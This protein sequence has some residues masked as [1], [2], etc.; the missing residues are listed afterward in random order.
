MLSP[1]GIDISKASF[2]VELSVNEKLR[3]RRFSNQQ[4]GFKELCAWLAKHKAG[5]VHAC[6][7]ATGR[8]GDDLAVHLYQAGHIVSV[9]NPAQIKAFGESELLRNKDDRPD[10]GLIRR[11][12]EKQQPA[13]W[14]P[15]APQV[16]ELRAL[17]RHL[18]NL[19]DTRQQQL[20]RLEGV[21][22]KAVL[23]SLRK[24]VAHLDKEIASTEQQIQDH[25]DSDPDLQRQQQLLS[26]IKGIGKLTA[27]KLL[28][29]IEDF[30]SFKSA[31]QVAAYA[32][33][34]PRNNRSGTLRGKTR[35][36][37]TGNARLRK[38]LF[39]PSMVAKRHNPIVR[40]FC[41]RLTH[42]GK[43][44]MEVI[45]AAM[46]KLIHIAFGVLKSG[47]FFDPDHELLLNSRS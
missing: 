14:Q 16:L 26:S 21:K 22:T 2:H 39:F 4:E 23:K 42:N 9:I 35:L 32:G 25:I 43:N 34:T 41:Q 3:H 40:A 33:L 36:S 13:A 15:P 27:A 24:L 5:Q 7:E 28:A 47:K 37:K 1:L 6:L 44:K 10:A 12:C 46:R 17:T 19:R 18:E 31:R 29:E 20:N 38:A 30:S 45:G 8:Y 11:F